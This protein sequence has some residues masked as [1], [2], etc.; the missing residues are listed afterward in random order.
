M[1]PIRLPPLRERLED[2]PELIRHFLNLVVQEGLPAKKLTQEALDRMSL[3]RWP[4][5]VREL[6]N[7]VRRL[8]ALYSQEVIGLDVI[9]AELSE[10]GTIPI[11]VEIT[12]EG[13]G[14]SVARHIQGFFDKH[15]DELPPSGLYD[16]V[17]KEVERPLIRLTLS[18]TRGNQNPR[19][20]RSGVKPK[21]AA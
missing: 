17:L 4:G 11:P 15:L 5:N 13:L 9:E 1:V 16:R 21:Y 19:G 10:V 20:R 3:Y 7:M 2:V 12:E 8:A 14:D 18:A 6:E